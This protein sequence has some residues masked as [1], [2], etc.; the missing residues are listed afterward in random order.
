MKEFSAMKAIFQEMVI[1]SGN[2]RRLFLL[3]SNLETI[4]RTDCFIPMK[5]GFTITVIPVSSKPV[6]EFLNMTSCRHFLKNTLFYANYAKLVIFLFKVS[7]PTDPHVPEFL[8]KFFDKQKYPA[9]KDRR[10][11][12]P[13]PCIRKG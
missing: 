8:Q 11:L 9:R 10:H 1:A 12:Q 6:H 5:Q 3:R 4:E 2:C 13:N 7:P